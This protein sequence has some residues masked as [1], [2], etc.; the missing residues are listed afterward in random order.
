MLSVAHVA[1]RC[2]EDA[3]H[4]AARVRCDR[5]TRA[6]HALQ[7]LPQRK[8]HSVRPGHNN[9]HARAAVAPLP[10]HHACPAA[11]AVRFSSSSRISS[12][13]ARC[14]RLSS[15]SSFLAQSR[16]RSQFAFLCWTLSSTWQT[17]ATAAQGVSGATRIARADI[18][19]EDSSCHATRLAVVLLGR[20]RLHNR[21]LRLRRVRLRNLR[22]TNQGERRNA[23]AAGAQVCCRAPLLLSTP[24]RAA[25][26]CE[27]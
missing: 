24:G 25:R 10:R 20:R 4:A 8:L 12:I 23:S 6:R 26:S 5:V 1:R 22:R 27:T 15:F 13:M 9:Q 2:C 3:P 19:R 7:R 16:R 11:S 21:L 18:A 14:V 17:S